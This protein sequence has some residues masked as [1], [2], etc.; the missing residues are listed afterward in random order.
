VRVVPSLAE[1]VGDAEDV[2]W[3]LHLNVPVEID[4]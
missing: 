4:A 1:S 2:T 3:K